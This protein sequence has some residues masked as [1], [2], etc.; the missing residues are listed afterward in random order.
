MRI[1]IV[2]SDRAK[3]FR[4]H[5]EGC[6]DVEKDIWKGDPGRRFGGF[7]AE[8]IDV[9]DERAPWSEVVESDALR[10]AVQDHLT[11]LGDGGWTVSND[12]TICACARRAFNELESCREIVEKYRRNPHPLGMTQAQADALARIKR[13]ER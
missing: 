8:T 9:T 13:L 3:Q 11:G 5:A 6:A 4:V 7:R 1:T 2:G 12:A 10:Q